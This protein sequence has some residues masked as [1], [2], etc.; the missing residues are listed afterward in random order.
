[1]ETR[2]PL[3]QYHGMVYSR[4][5]FREDPGINVAS[6]FTEYFAR[7]LV[8]ARMQKSNSSCT[9]YKPYTPFRIGTHV[10]EDIAFA[11]YGS[12]RRAS[13]I[14]LNV[15][16][17]IE[18]PAP[19]DHPRSEKPRAAILETPKGTLVRKTLGEMVNGGFYIAIDPRGLAQY[20]E[21]HP[22]VHIDSPRKR[23]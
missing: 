14:A 8:L 20:L 11:E 18:L 19:K 15:G 16:V 2:S 7:P 5:S 21:E 9:G 17:I 3:L 13:R 6:I 12:R 10:W 22:M 1:M 4:P 23:L